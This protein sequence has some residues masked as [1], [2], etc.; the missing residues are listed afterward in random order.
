MHICRYPFHE[1]KHITI[2]NL[3]TS[4]N[5]QKACG[6]VAHERGSG[7]EVCVAARGT[8]QT[9][10]GCGRRDCSETIQDIGPGLAIYYE[11]VNDVLKFI[12]GIRILISRRP[13]MSK[14]YMNFSKGPLFGL[15]SILQTLVVYK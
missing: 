10:E 8:S 6:D 9:V 3:I 13:C 2:Y 11:I 4:R 5:G 7:E 14:C 12:V 15:Q 1:S